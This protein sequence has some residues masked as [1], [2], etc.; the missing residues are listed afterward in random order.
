MTDRLE[1]LD[2]F[3]ER[4][5]RAMELRGYSQADLG[6]ACFTSRQAVTQVLAPE[7]KPRSRKKGPTL[8]H[9]VKLADALRVDPGWLAFGYGS[10]PESVSDD[11]EPGAY[12]CASKTSFMAR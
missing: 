1:L 9:I 4:L 8:W 6:K 2:G 11:T 3:R 12:S 10:P 7:R 5:R